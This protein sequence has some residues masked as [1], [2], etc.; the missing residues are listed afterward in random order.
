M[1][2]RK[3][4]NN[5][6]PF[7]GPRAWRRRVPSPPLKRIRISAEL[8]VFLDRMARKEATR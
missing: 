1:N 4:I 6:V 3:N 8:M 2:G 7:P 5:V